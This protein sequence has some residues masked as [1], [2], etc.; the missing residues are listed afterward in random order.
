MDINATILG[1]GISFSIFT[2]ICMKYVWPPL[3]TM[4]A[5]REQKIS[6]GLQN[7]EEA[8]RS[9]ANARNQASEL[10]TEAKGQASELIEQA[11]RRANQLI[12]EA[13]SQAETE[14]FKIKKQADSQLE[15]EIIKA[16]E[17]LK[18]QVTFLAVKGAEKIMEAEIDQNKHSQ[19]LKQLS[20]EL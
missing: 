4:M 14:A 18:S 8:E 11:N 2:Y 7:A 5:E 10:I 1:Q 16:R 20:A 19:M 3:R 17:S 9:L 15:Q 13:R 6:K 12:E